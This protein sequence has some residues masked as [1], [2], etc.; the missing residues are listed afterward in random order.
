MYAYTVIYR[1]DFSFQFWDSIIPSCSLISLIVIRVLLNPRILQNSLWDA[2]YRMGKKLSK[3]PD[4]REKKNRSKF[5]AWKVSDRCD[6]QSDIKQRSVTVEKRI[7]IFDRRL[8]NYRLSSKFNSQIGLLLG[9]RQ[10]CDWD[11]R[12]EIFYIR[13]IVRIIRNN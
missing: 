6:G 9:K 11:Y 2:I 7:S 13:K 3:R 8:Y 4:R 12:R 5:E 1:S 10:Y